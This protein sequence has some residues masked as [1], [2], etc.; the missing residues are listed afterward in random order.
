MRTVAQLDKVLERATSGQFTFPPELHGQVTVRCIIDTTGH[1]EPG[2]MRVIASAHPV[3]DSIALDFVRN[4]AFTPGRVHGRPVRV[5]YEERVEFP[6]ISGSTTLANPYPKH[7]GVFDVNEV[8][9]QPERLSGPGPVY[10]AELLKA[11]VT[12][13]VVVG[14]ILD[15]M[16]R[17]EPASL[18][19][20][21]T[22]NVGFNESAQAAVRLSVFSPGRVRG[23][24]VR[25]AFQ[26]PLT[27]STNH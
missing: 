6:D 26:M 8:D 2:S 27:Y 22:D 19:I 25:V 24:A 5:V 16:G 1:P 11:G 18:R 20:L 4:S 14:A 13:M 21:F 7:A 9:V 10:P 23:R 17:V 12:G 15:T 3:L